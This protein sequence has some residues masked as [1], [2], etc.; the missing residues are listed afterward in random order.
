[1]TIVLLDTGAIREE[2]LDLANTPHTVPGVL[3]ELDKFFSYARPKAKREKK[4]IRRELNRAVKSKERKTYQEAK[5][6]VELVQEEEGLNP[7]PLVVRLIAEGINAPYGIEFKRTGRRNL[8]RKIVGAA[9]EYATAFELF[10]LE[11]VTSPNG[12]IISTPERSFDRRIHVANCE[13]LEE[14]FRQYEEIEK[15]RAQELES[16]SVRHAE[17]HRAER[18]RQYF[19]LKPNQVVNVDSDERIAKLFAVSGK[20]AAGILYETHYAG[21]RLRDISEREFAQRLHD[22]IWHEMDSYGRSSPRL[23]EITA[24]TVR[25]GL[26]EFYCERNHDERRLRVSPGTTDINLV[27]AA[28][29]LAKRGETVCVRTT[30]TDITFLIQAFNEIYQTTKRKVICELIPRADSYF[31]AARAARRRR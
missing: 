28:Y 24:E 14:R 31:E 20:T 11:V 15:D 6:I 4:A 2:E 25:A 16:L 13:E 12:A 5:G 26:Y 27:S 17:L 30:D 9:K 29:H 22:H 18:G 8:R 7:N 1:M 10:G 3:A 19:T 21:T 23:D